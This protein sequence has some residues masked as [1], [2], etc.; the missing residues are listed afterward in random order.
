MVVEAPFVSTLLCRYLQGKTFTYDANRCAS[1]DSDDTIHT[2][3]GSDKPDTEGDAAGAKRQRHP[4]SK[5][6][7][8]HTFQQDAGH[9]IK[10][11]PDA[12]NILFLPMWDTAKNRCF[13]Q[14]LVWTNN[15]E[16]VFT[17]EKDLAY[18][19]AFAN[20]IMAKIQHVDVEMAEKAKTNLINSITH[21]LRN[22]LHGI[23]GTADILSD[24]AMNALQHGMVHTIESCGRTLLDTTN[25]LLDL[26]FINKYQKNRSR[27]RGPQ[28]ATQRQL[29]AGDIQDGEKRGYS[30]VKLDQVLE[31]V[32]E[33]VFAGY[34]FYHHPQASPPALTNSSSRVA[35]NESNQTGVEH[36]QVTIIFDVADAEW[37]FYT[38]AGTWRRILLNVFG[39]ALKYT[40]SGFIH[41][42]L[43]SFRKEKEEE[44]RSA[45][46]SSG[47]QAAEEFEVV[48]T[49]KNTGRGIGH[50]YLQGDLFTP[51]S[52]EDSIISGSSLGLSIVRQ[53]VGSLSG[54]IEINSTKNSGTE[55]AIRTMLTRHPGSSPDVSSSSDLV[56][57]SLRK[58]IEGK[59]MGLL[60]FGFP[61][62]SKRDTALYSSLEQ[63]C[64]DWFG[65]NVTSVSQLQSSEQ[66]SF[67]F[68]LAV[69]TELDSEDCK[70]RNLFSWIQHPAGDDEG[71]RSPV[72]VICQS[73]EEA[74]SMFVAAKNR[75]ESHVF[76][77]IS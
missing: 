69:Q 67:D 75:D 45:S 66:R 10:L 22:P 27:L 70:G 13:A 59:S 61:L 50:E 31:E 48:L 29:P 11:F 74:H 30:R 32:T 34:S 54:S 46:E 17:A 36:N 14:I 65:L 1:D 23:L 24:K 25:S 28:R 26:N 43:K 38:H 3:S 55:L 56:F 6:R 18:I 52:Q 77:F 39:N 37:D 76:E 33:C 15:P 4:I 62:R 5:K 8:K 73:P 40:S 7:R 60:G 42:G 49:I 51:F 12:R 2:V 47:N 9:L 72:V 16:H 41:I 57:S 35:E 63:L 21:E 53:A 64:R 20:S 68:Y 58:H 71:C 19:S 44:Q